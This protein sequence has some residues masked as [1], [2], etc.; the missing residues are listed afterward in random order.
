MEK[1]FGHAA[2]DCLSPAYAI[3]RDSKKDLTKTKKYDRI[4]NNKRKV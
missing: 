2:F 4:T 1:D 3:V